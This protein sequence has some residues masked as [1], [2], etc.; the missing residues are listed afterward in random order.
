V[1]ALVFR[2]IKTFEDASLHTLTPAYWT[3]PEEAL[4]TVAGVAAG[5]TAAALVEVALGAAEEDL[6]GVGLDAALVDAALVGAAL[7]AAALVGAA[8]PG[9]HWE[10][11]SFCFWQENPEA[12]AVSPVQLE[13]PP[14]WP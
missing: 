5:L 9:T 6:A 11:Q 3:P 4:T 2:L 1:N 7:V 14:H 13:P 10:Y 8:V 12:Q